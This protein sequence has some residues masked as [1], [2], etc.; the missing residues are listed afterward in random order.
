MTAKCYGGDITRKRKLLEKQKAG[1]QRMKT[2]GSVNIPRAFMAVLEQEPRRPRSEKP[3]PRTT[4]R[5]LVLTAI[6]VAC[7]ALL[8]I[9]GQ[10]RRGPRRT[11]AGDPR[12]RG[13]PRAHG[14]RPPAGAERRRPDRLGRG[15]DLRAW[16]IGSVHIDDDQKSSRPRTTSGNGRSSTELKEIE[17]EFNERAQEMQGEYGEI[18]EDDPQFPE[19]KGRMQAL[20]QEY[21]QFTQLSRGRITKLEAEQLE[22][23]RELIE[24]TEIVADQRSIA[25][26]SVHPHR[27]AG[28]QNA[29]QAMLQIQLRTFLRYPK[30]ST[31]PA[32]DR[33]AEHGVASSR[34][35]SHAR[36]PRGAPP[37]PRRGQDIG[38]RAPDG[39]WSPPVRDPAGDDQ[40]E[41]AEVG[42]H[43]ERQSVHRAPA[44]SHRGRDLAGPRD[45]R[46]QPDPGRVRVRSPTSP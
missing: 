42:I 20:M 16:S 35:G 7:L 17:A 39:G 43:V 18:G 30:P 22:Q 28:T 10:R 26:C 27:G 15:T 45:P 44:L 21:Q 6:V 46:L 29:E 23:Y 12:S 25:S 36:I 40:V 24:A 8:R 11:L 9:G 38:P 2:I 33:G 31:S 4:D 1:K 41:V 19:A 34:A 37:R 5:L 13:E 3:P 32:G 14:N